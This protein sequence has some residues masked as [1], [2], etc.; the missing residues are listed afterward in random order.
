MTKPEYNLTDQDYSERGHLSY[1]G[2]PIVDFH[3]HVMRSSS[4]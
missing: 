3:S 4:A 2:P 1:Q